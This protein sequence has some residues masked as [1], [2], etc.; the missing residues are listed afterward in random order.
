MAKLIGQDLSNQVGVLQYAYIIHFLTISIAIVQNVH[1]V[2]QLSVVSS[3][4]YEFDKT[5]IGRLCK[6]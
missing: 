1:E 3:C 2:R 5:I 6:Y 4:S